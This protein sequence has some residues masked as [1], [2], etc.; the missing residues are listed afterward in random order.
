[1]E[2]V[3]KRPADLPI[4]LGQA[5][6]DIQGRCRAATANSCYAKVQDAYDEL[7]RVEGEGYL[8]R[9]ACIQLLFVG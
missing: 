2:G 3:E 9:G 7:N 5:Q 4:P 6:T 1:M 8:C